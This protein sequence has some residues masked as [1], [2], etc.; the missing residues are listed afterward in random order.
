MQ[1]AK[2]LN[3]CKGCNDIQ[4]SKEHHG[5]DDLAHL[6]IDLII[7]KL[8]QIVCLINFGWVWIWIMNGQEIR[9]YLISKEKLV[10]FLWQQFLKSFWKSIRML[11]IKMFMWSLNVCHV[12]LTI[13]STSNIKGKPCLPTPCL[14]NKCCESYGTAVSF[15]T[16]EIIY[17]HLI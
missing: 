9:H 8:C 16:F 10:T 3:A 7:I 13:R 6:R 15:I 11:V 14:L 4:N 5:N 1:H 2:K 17:Y 12:G